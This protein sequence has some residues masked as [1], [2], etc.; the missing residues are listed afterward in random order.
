VPL[1]E[2]GAAPLCG[3]AVT[4]AFVRGAS[5]TIAAKQTAGKDEDRQASRADHDFRIVAD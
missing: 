2:I 3:V 5:A 1:L 4:A